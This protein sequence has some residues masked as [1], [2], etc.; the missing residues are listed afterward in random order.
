M[1]RKTI[2]NII[3]II[4]L[5]VVVIGVFLIVSN[6]KSQKEEVTENKQKNES[7]GPALT[8]KKDKEEELRREKEKQE[9]AKKKAA[10]DKDKKKK[11]NNKQSNSKSN[12]ALT[13]D[14]NK[15]TAYLLEK[16]IK[17]TK[18][19]EEE[20]QVEE[21]ATENMIK[22]VEGA[23]D[24]NSDHE[25]DIRN[26]SIKFKDT[27]NYTDTT[28]NGTFKYD[29]IVKT[30]KSDKSTGTTQLNQT[31]AVTFIK[32]DGKYKLDKLSK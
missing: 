19:S 2:I 12:D 6:T 31:S 28:I 14:L 23:E 16:T 5:L 3:S 27:H 32:K 30:S 21:L 9:E 11:E 20:K 18:N 1:S 7:V 17:G 22:Q 25:V 26:T 15:N 29:L 8:A 13:A 10:E 4:I 24:S